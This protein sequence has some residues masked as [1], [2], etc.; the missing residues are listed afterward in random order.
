MFE[1]ACRSNSSSTSS[2]SGEIRSKIRLAVSWTSSRIAV[3]LV[4]VVISHLTL[5]PTRYRRRLRTLVRSVVR[6]LHV[7]AKVFRLQAGD[8]LLQSIAIFAR[9]SHHVALN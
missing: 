1:R 9:D 2:N 5:W 6:K 8:H 4:A 7:D 3:E